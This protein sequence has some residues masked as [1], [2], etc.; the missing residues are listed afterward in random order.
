[1]ESGDEKTWRLETGGSEIAA[2]AT[3]AATSLLVATTAEQLWTTAVGSV[4]FDADVNGERV[5][6]SAVSSSVRDTFTRSVTDG[7]STSDSGHT[8]TNSG[9]AAA[10]YDVN[11]SK[12]FQTHPSANVIHHSTIDIGTSDHRVR[13]YVNL[14]VGSVAGAGATGFVLARML[15]TFNWYAARVGYATSG[16]VTLQIAKM[17]G[18]V[19]NIVG[20]GS[21]SLGTV[22]NFAATQFIV[23]L[24]VRGSTLSASAW[25]ATDTEPF[26]WRVIETDTD[27]TTGTLVGLASRRDTGNTDAS[28]I[29]AW[30]NF[31]VL[32]PQAF[33]VT[34]G[35]AGGAAAKAHSVGAP[36]KLWR[37]R[38]LAL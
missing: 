7:W 32:N 9:G 34:R 23:Q 8:W 28:L 35:V 24:D 31:A 2:A 5:T 10:D 18:G 36:V 15:D 33:T 21:W 25:D 30:D 12:G 1:M 29:F 37:A 13:G 6:V 11:G 16:V 19:G 38:G 14:S 4:P 3:A 20:T 27:L 17:V 26:T 22:A